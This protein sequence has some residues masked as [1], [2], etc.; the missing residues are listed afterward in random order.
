[1]F[2]QA[3]PAGEKAGPCP[4]CEARA[5]QIDVSDSCV[6]AGGW[7]KMRCLICGATGPDAE[8]DTIDAAA[9]EAVRLWSLARPPQKPLMARLLSSISFKRS[10]A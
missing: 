9:E 10:A 2:G 5:V 3:H 4:F 6:S 7:A 1:M 8:A